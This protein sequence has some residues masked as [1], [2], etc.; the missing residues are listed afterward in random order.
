MA[1]IAKALLLLALAAS[2]AVAQNVKKTREL[3]EVDFSTNA[4]GGCQYVGETAMDSYVADSLTLA[5]SGVQLMNDYANGGNP[6]ADRLV[7]ALFKGSRR[8]DRTRVRRVTQD[9]IQPSSITICP[10]AFDVRRGIREVQPNPIRKQDVDAG[11][12]NSAQQIRHVLPTATTLFHELFHLVL[13][14]SD[15]KPPDDGEVYLFTEVI[16]LNVAASARNPES[17]A[18]AA[19]AYD[20]TRNAGEVGGFRVEFYTGYATQG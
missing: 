13:G 11:R 8:T 16:T 10:I 14:T 3:F 9:L 1:S 17:F 2:Q 19:V 7:H 6:E 5:L 20:Y 18:F 4:R 12:V 15:T